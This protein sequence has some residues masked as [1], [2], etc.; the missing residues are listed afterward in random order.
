MGKFL[1]LL[2]VLSVIACFVAGLSGN[3][4]LAAHCIRAAFILAIMAIMARVFA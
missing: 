1:G 3:A 4:L 2:S